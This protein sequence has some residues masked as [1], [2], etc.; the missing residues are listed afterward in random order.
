MFF[1][2]TDHTPSFTRN[3]VVDGTLLIKLVTHR[4]APAPDA[5]AQERDDDNARPPSLP[6]L[7]LLAPL[8]G[9]QDVEN[10]E[11]A[12]RPSMPLRSPGMKLMLAIIK[13]NV[14]IECV[15]SMKL[16][17]AIIKHNQALFTNNRQACTT[18]FPS[19]THEGAAT[20]GHTA[21]ANSIPE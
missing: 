6:P 20:S 16:M 15:L 21:H 4:H 11:A 18:A 8:R 9:R 5:P 10:G 14:S 2:I 13:H 17:L 7:N 12:A 19:D 1:S 3:I